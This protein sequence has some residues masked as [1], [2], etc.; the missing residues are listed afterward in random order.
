M[1]STYG[2]RG[3]ANPGAQDVGARGLDIDD[4]AVVGVAGLGV[5]LVGGTDGADRSLGSG[6]RV[7]GINVL[8]ASSDSEE[9]TSIDKSGG[10]VVDRGGLAAAQRHVGDSA[11][12]AAAVG[13]IIGNEVDASNDTG[14]GMG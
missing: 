9:D 7:L 4:G 2:S 13:N 3:G 5:V 8:V 1:G 6:R 11:V 10:G 12:G 14:A